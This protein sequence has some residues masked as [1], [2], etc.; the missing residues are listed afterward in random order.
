MQTSGANK[1]SMLRASILL[2]LIGIA[3]VIQRPEA[4]GEVL[5]A[6]L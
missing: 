2:L 6:D 1:R 5:V 3:F 4:S